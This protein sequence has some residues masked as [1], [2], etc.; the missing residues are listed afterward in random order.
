MEVLGPRGTLRAFVA[1][2][3]PRDDRAGGPGR[4]PEHLT[5]RFLGEVPEDR[6]QR[7]VELLAPVGRAH[8]PFAMTL[9]GVGAFPSPDRPRVVWVGVSRGRPELEELARAVRASLAPEFGPDRETFVPHLTLFRVRGPSDRAAAL[10]LLAG[11]RPAPPPRSTRVRE[12]VLKQSVLGREGAVHR[13]LAS[14]PLEAAG[15]TGDRP[16][17]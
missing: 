17:T 4:A 10:D 5:L 2:E 6:T 3:V 15:G 16:T 13:T 9:E 14:F 12:F 8:P 7:L 1:V 11:R